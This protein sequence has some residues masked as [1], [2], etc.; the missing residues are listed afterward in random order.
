VGRVFRTCV[1]ASLGGLGMGGFLLGC[2]LGMLIGILI[3]S[4]KEE[5]DEGL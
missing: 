1:T 4:D 5:D 3:M 2:A